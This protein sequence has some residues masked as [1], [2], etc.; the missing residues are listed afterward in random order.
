MP[1]ASR[2][3]RGEAAGA[4][5][6]L[7][8]SCPAAGG[9]RQPHAA[10]APE[11]A[12]PIARRSRE[13]ALPAATKEAAAMIR[14]MHMTCWRLLVPLSADDLLEAALARPWQ[15][16]AGVRPTGC[17]CGVSALPRRLVAGASGLELRVCCIDC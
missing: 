11:I 5:G 12:A 16:A 8:V 2:L 7:G 14:V 17:V 6:L 1:A 10:T 4:C 13:A 9:R 15:C 3:R